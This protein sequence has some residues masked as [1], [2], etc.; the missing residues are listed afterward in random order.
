VP[1]RISVGISIVLRLSQRLDTGWCA[2]PFRFMGCNSM[3][4]LLAPRVLR[5]EEE[6]TKLSAIFRI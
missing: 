5:R 4:D 1:V 6:A 3:S 2:C